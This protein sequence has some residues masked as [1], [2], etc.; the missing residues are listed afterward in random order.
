[1]TKNLPCFRCGVCCR[2]YQVHL[3]ED[4]LEQLSRDLGLSRRHFV[5]DFTDPRWPGEKTFLLK[6]ENGGCVFLQNINER[7]TGCRIH[8]FR[9][10][11]CRE[12]S[13]G[14]GK[15]E[16]RKGAGLW[17]VEIDEQGNF[18]GDTGKVEK[19]KQFLDTLD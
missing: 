13:A 12:W 4:E 15:K 19:F 10:R 3:E 7:I 8:S 5:K 6:H 17:S 16:C 2:A 18:T 9:P 14:S 1:V 11:A